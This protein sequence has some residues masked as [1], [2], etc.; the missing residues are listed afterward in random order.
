V[1]LDGDLGEE[2]AM[3]GFDLLRPEFLLLLPLA[4]LLI[5]VGLWGFSRRRAEL[6]KLVAPSRIAR[7]APGASRGRPLLRLGLAGAALFL[8]TVGALG[9][10]RGYTL[11]ETVHRGLDLVVCIDTSRS[12]LAQDLR[13][14][15]L[16][17]AKREVIGLLSR[18]RGDRCALIAFSGDAREIAPLTHDYRT[19]EGLLDYV[20][21]ADNRRG[22]TDL[23]APIQHALEIFD[24]RTGAHEAIVLLTDGEDLEG[25]GAEAA[26]LASERGI[27]VYV[28]GVG[29]A[30]GGKIPVRLGN[31]REGFLRGPD[32][33]EVVT[34]LD[35]ETL[36]A[37]AEATEGE[38]LSTGQSATPL[39]D[40]HARRIT[41]LAGREL[42]GGKHRVP[43]DRYQWALGLA[44]ACMLC[45]VGLRERRR[46]PGRRGKV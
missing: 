4:A 40:L 45:E 10:V 7:F 18:L 13:P 34:R 14:N 5:P 32:G 27:R 42:E 30:D 19:L 16:E 38:Y 2:V 20:G 37:L 39:E 9:P 11:R 3:I 35:G 43:H 28:V 1:D 46:A 31:A 17:R 26:K 25:R 6:A 21:V 29:S 23:A 44:A 41:R 24:G 22:G 12:M 8:L 36:R 15:R 33:E